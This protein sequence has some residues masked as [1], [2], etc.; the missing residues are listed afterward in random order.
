MT[1]SSSAA[2]GSSVELDELYVMRLGELVRLAAVL[3]ADDPEDVVQDAF[4]RFQERAQLRDPAAAT[5]YLRRTVA[6]LTNSR[7]RHLRI[8]RA[9]RLPT[10]DTPSAE[11]VALP[12]DE[13]RRLVQ[14]VWR[15]PRRQREVI[16][17][18][19]WS[20]CSEADIAETLGVSVGAVKSHS[21]RAIAKLR[22]DAGTRHDRT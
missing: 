16:V 17:L 9:A 18:R 12:S 2:A 5:A 22:L 7:L 21:A 10:R 8:A 11:S 4:L 1:G 15:L 19:Y 3:G 20:R 6:N 14:A 13:E